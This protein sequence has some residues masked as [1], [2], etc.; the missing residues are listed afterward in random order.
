[1]PKF[2]RS[3]IV[4]SLV[5]LSLNSAHAVVR[6]VQKIVATGDA[7][8]DGVG[9]PLFFETLQT[10]MINNSGEVAFRGSIDNPVGDLLYKNGIWVNSSGTLD[11]RIR[12]GETP[13]GMPTGITAKFTGFQSATFNDTGQVGYL[14]L[15]DVYAHRAGYWTSS[16]STTEAIG[17]QGTELASLS[18]DLFSVNYDPSLN[19]SGQ[20]AFNSW[21]IPHGGTTQRSGIFITDGNVA[22]IVGYQG[23]PA[24]GTDR[25]FGGISRHY[26]PINA[27]GETAFSIALRNPSTGSEN[28]RG[29]YK[30]NSSS[31]ELVAASGMTAPGTSAT[32]NN[33]AYTATI[34]LNSDG[35][36]AFHS[37][38]SGVG[39][40]SL[41][42]FGIW[43]T[44]GDSLELVAREGDM[45][46]SEVLNG[47]YFTNI[48]MPLIDDSDQV[49]FRAA[50]TGIPAVTFSNLWKSRD[51]ELSLIASSGTPA[52]GTNTS[53]SNLQDGF[54]ATNRL[55]QVAFQALAGN[56]R[57]IW[58]EDPSGAIR[59]IVKVGDSL[60][61]APG[62]HRT[63]ASIDN[64]FSSN[65]SDGKSRSFNDAGQLVFNATF[66]DGGEGIF[67]SDVAGYYLADFDRDGDVDNDDLDDWRSA[68]TNGTALGDA[69]G[70][71][72]SSGRDF[73][74][75]Q[76]QVGLGTVA[77]SITVPE[78]IGLSLFAIGCIGIICRRA[79]RCI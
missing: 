65:G 21:V 78:P 2:L 24:P 43:R 11:E 19:Y 59:L 38:L 69:D 68:Y 50:T 28:E 36:V 25:T 67:V 55:G 16:S 9:S 39:V 26:P 72:V 40:N 61:I 4:A 66:T 12:A 33:N 60:E 56:Q 32:F 10:G 42:D 13:P 71:G 29:I 57:G 35:D 46:P 17:V 20:M 52:P 49:V 7:L 3:L 79:T 5:L 74:I 76:R 37:G 58:A 63:I 23:E 75:W 47:Q 41:N 77:E 14:G 22:E 51:G 15:T 6:D 30:G 64:L 31:L 48:V 53:F 44:R 34:P 8:P 54:F 27:S 45:V 62:D 1:M 18:A 73:L 70:D